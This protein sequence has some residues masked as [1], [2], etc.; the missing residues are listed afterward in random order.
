M[1]KC[2]CELIYLLNIFCIHVHAGS[3]YNICSKGTINFLRR[4]DGQLSI[5]D[6]S[7]QIW[8]G[9][10]S[11]ES[12]AAS[13]FRQKREAKRADGCCRPLFSLPVGFNLRTR[14]RT[15]VLLSSSPIS[16]SIHIYH[17]VLMPQQHRDQLLFFFFWHCVCLFLC[18]RKYRVLAQHI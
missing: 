1:H 16:P 4:G 15:S 10:C 6:E 17:M 2:R 3:S 13:P 5:C 11:A 12:S 14:E 9:A 8:G 18:A 7:E